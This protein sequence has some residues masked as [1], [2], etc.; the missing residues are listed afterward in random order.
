MGSNVY[1][2]LH[3]E[4]PYRIRVGVGCL[5]YCP[6]RD[7]WGENETLRG[8]KVG[9]S[10][11]VWKRDWRAETECR[12]FRQVGRGSEAVHLIRTSSL[13]LTPPLFPIPFTPS[14][15][16]HPPRQDPFGSSHR[17]PKTTSEALPSL[18]KLIPKRSLVLNFIV[19]LSVLLLSPSRRIEDRRRW[20]D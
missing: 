15:V 10:Y 16:Y 1:R 4:G 7:W 11:L 2:L 17:P 5:S 13:R 18:L 20:V 8:T 14:P 9:L 19:S 12:P 6:R 3:P